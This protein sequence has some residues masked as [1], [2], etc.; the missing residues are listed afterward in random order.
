MFSYPNLYPLGEEPADLL[1]APLLTGE[2]PLLAWTTP[3]PASGWRWVDE[4]C[5]R[6]GRRR[7][8][9]WPGRPWHRAHR[10]CP[11]S[12]RDRWNGLDRLVESDDALGSA[13]QLAPRGVADYVMV[14][15]GAS[16]ALPRPH[17]RPS[18]PSLR[19]R[20]AKRG[21]D[22]DGRP[23]NDGP[24]WPRRCPGRKGPDDDSRASAEP[25]MVRG[26]VREWHD[27]EGWACSTAPR[28]LV[29]AG[30]STR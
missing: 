29:A 18:V 9:W 25:P 7:R 20:A 23:R 15:Y 4:G 8:F 11:G 27:Y 14:A 24:T 10:R 16:T 5:V 2:Y 17:P 22:V 13:R 26:V 30:C 19:C 21:T 28:L 3:T 1:V 6:P 12:R